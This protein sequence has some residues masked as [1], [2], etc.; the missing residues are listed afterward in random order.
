MI[1]D[2]ISHGIWRH[3]CKKYSL[4]RLSGNCDVSHYCIY[5]KGI[6]YHTKVYG[7]TFD[8]NS[9]IAQ[10]TQ[11]LLLESW[12]ISG[13]F[14]TLIWRTGDTVQNLESPGLSGRVDSTECDSHHHS[15]PGL[16]RNRSQ[17]FIQLCPSCAKAQ[18]SLWLETMV[19]NSGSL[20]FARL[21][22]DLTIAIC[23]KITSIY[24]SVP[25]LLVD[26]WNKQ[27]YDYIYGIGFCCGANIH[28]VFMFPNM[29]SLVR[30]CIC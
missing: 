1:D 28:G 19:F 11:S 14:H 13:W 16:P 25:Q 23:N 29:S 30:E 12:W 15:L 4:T 18:M 7:E 26:S 24:H 3:L 9:K 8:V 6:I 10:T 27:V 17:E 21:F 2:I 5:C 20:S 22:L